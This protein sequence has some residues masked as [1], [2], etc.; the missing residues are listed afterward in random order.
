MLHQWLVCEPSSETVLLTFIRTT[1]PLLS[2]H[3]FL[4]LSLSAAGVGSAVMGAVAGWCRGFT[5]GVRETVCSGEV[6]WGW[7]IGR[8][9]SLL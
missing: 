8:R 7:R 4:F 3:A 1:L 2:L 5:G 6:M 9:G